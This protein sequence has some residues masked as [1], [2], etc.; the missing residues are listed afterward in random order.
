MNYTEIYPL[1]IYPVRFKPAYV[2]SYDCNV[3]AESEN[4][5]QHASLVPNIDDDVWQPMCRVKTNKS[6]EVRINYNNFMANPPRKIRSHD[7]N[8]LL[9]NQNWI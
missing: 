9:H 2:L 5:N 3:V 7:R 6:K 1:Q 8:V 4:E